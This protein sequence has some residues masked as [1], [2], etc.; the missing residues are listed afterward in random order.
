M[1]QLERILLDLEPFLFL[2]VA[3]AFFRSSA[4]RRLPALGT[5]FAVRG[6]SMVLLNWVLCFRGMPQCG[7][8]LYTVYFLSYWLFYITEAVT[9]FFVVQELFGLAMEPVPGLRRLGLLA[10]R[11]ACIVSVIVAI[12]V[13]AL[14]AGMASSSSQ[15]F[16]AML[17]S[18]GLEAMRCVDILELCLLAFLALSIHSLG[19]S[20]RS[21]LFG[22]A[23][24]FGLQA[25]CELVF[26]ALAV[27]YP[28]LTS[29]ANLFL[30]CG[31]TVAFVIWLAYFLVPEPSTERTMI[32]LP[33]TSV[34]ARWNSLASGIGQT[35]QVVAAQPSSGFFLQD[36]EGVVERVLAKNPVVAD[37]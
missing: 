15:P 7:T 30:Q 19:R 2:T 12:G 24:A 21:R 20:F 9:L 29:S 22:I 31:V 27:R 3:A 4:R 8:T 35:P 16:A 14:P 33:P 1:A 17:G 6:G 34:M 26:T 32:V 18:I 25:G 36:I 10:F 5:Y 11:W 28:G 13:V 23:L 37:R